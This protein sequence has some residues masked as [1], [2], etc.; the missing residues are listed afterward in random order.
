MTAK[1]LAYS[2]IDTSGSGYK[3]N[4]LERGSVRR[5]LA[6]KTVV[7]APKFSTQPIYAEAS[8]SAPGNYSTTAT[9]L[10]PVTVATPTQSDSN[11]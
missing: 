6:G 8:Q 3:V 1:N 2:N 10:Q 7:A 4:R 5:R 9:N 11:A